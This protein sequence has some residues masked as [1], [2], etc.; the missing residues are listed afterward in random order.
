MEASMEDFLNSSSFKGD[1]LEVCFVIIVEERQGLS[2]VWWDR[3]RDRV[4]M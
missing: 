1:R 2:R 3:Q 4:N